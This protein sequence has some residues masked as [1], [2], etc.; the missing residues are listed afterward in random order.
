MK[1]ILKDLIAKSGKKTVVSF[2]NKDKRNSFDE[3]FGKEKI[4]IASK[5]IGN[6]ENSIALSKKLAEIQ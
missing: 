3:S 1:N 6:D 2:V 5:F 4:E